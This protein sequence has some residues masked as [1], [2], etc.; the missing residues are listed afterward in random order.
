MAI[1]F[2][3]LPGEILCHVISLGSSGE[4]DADTPHLHSLF[5]TCSRMSLLVR[6]F[7]WQNVQ[8]AADYTNFSYD[9]FMRSLTENL[10]LASMVRE[11]HLRWGKPN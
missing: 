8:L 11:L 7:L 4:V 3:S 5:D 6:P 10:N 2:W 9:H 1:H